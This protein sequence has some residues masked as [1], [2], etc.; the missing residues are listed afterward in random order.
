MV[1]QKDG[2][3]IEPRVKRRVRLFEKL[4][5][6][7]DKRMDNAYENALKSCQKPEA[8]ILSLD[9]ISPEVQAVRLEQLKRKL[10]ERTDRL[11]TQ[12]AG[13]NSSERYQRDV[14]RLLLT[15]GTVNT[16]ALYKAL[17]EMQ[18]HVYDEGLKNTCGLVH[19]YIMEG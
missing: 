14:L 13:L 1:E 18:G 11:R 3:G 19:R 9:E 4:L 15:K 16:W 7:N 10:D 5:S 6:F 8:R 2:I 12:Y 17:E